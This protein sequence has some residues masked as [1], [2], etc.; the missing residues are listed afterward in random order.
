MGNNL[1]KN[2]YVCICMPDSLFC[3]PETNIVSHLYSNKIYLKITALKKKKKHNGEFF[4]KRDGTKG[5]YTLCR[6]SSVNNE[7]VLVSFLK[8]KNWSI[9]DLYLVF[10]VQ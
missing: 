7:G 9:V 5:L 6:V 4:K 2:G 8:K 10:L 1:K 3:M